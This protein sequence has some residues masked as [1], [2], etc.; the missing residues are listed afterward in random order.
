MQTAGP[1]SLV[2]WHERGFALITCLACLPYLLTLAYLTGFTKG[3]P[4]Q[5]SHEV[6]LENGTVLE[7]VRFK[8]K[9]PFVRD[10]PVLWLVAKGKLRMKEASEVLYQKIESIF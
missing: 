3:S 7:C 9:V 4:V 8:I 5:E 2:P 1:K 10:L 6:T